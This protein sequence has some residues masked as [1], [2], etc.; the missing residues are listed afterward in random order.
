MTPR[1]RP[2]E[3]RLQLLAFAEKCR[4]APLG[5]PLHRVRSA[6]WLFYPLL[7]AL[8]EPGT[9]EAAE[10]AADAAGEAA[11][12]GGRMQVGACRLGHVL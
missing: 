11:A 9:A 7:R 6:R 1:R 8:A 2:E 12:A 5:G 4:F 3:A 10:A